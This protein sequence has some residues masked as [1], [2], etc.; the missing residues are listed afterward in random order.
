MDSKNQTDCGTH[1]TEDA[2]YLAELEAYQAEW[3]A[4]E[5][6][7]TTLRAK[8]KHIVKKRKYDYVLRFD[9]RY[10]IQYR[11]RTGQRTGS[12]GWARVSIDNPAVWRADTEKR[13][14]WYARDLEQ[15]KNIIGIEVVTVEKQ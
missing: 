12:Y 13:A 4:L 9:D 1:L 7:L 10:W 5:R 11:D 14:F 8:R 3:D 2:E 15:L 6:Q